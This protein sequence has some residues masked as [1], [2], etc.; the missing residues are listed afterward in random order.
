MAAKRRYKEFNDYPKHKLNYIRAFGQMLER[1][2]ERGLTSKEDWS[3][4][5]NVFKWWM[6]EDVNQISFFGE[7]L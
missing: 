6:G 3:S 4:G 7:D 5:E 2:K 1:R